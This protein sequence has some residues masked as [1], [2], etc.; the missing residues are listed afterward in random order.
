MNRIVIQLLRFYQLAIS[1]FL[2]PS[3]RYYPSCSNYAIEA[4][5]IHGVIKG[6]YFAVRRVLRCHPLKSGGLDPVPEKHTC[7]KPKNTKRGLIN[8]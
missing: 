5:Q 3:C 8:D 4:V 1:P 6:S 7:C 2:G